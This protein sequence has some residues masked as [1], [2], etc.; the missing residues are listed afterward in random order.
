MKFKAKSI[1]SLETSPVARE[2]VSFSYVG[3]S[4]FAVLERGLRLWTKHLGRNWVPLIGESSSQP[5]PFH[6]TAPH[7]TLRRFE[8]HDTTI[9]P[10]FLDCCLEL[11]LI[12]QIIAVRIADLCDRAIE[13]THTHLDLYRVPL[14]ET[15]R[16]NIP[17]DQQSCSLP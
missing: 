13:L 2:N 4:L 6:N 3:C 15:Q 7:S 5:L 11:S 8:P 16:D 14:H 12:S 17:T 10:S 1:Y 9:I